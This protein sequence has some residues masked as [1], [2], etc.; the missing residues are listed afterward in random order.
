MNILFVAPYV[1]SRIRV[2]PFHFLKELSKRHD[3]YVVALAEPGGSRFSGVQEI[4]EATRQLRVVPH[5]TARGCVQALLAAPTSRPMCTSYCHSVAMHDAVREAMQSIRFD[6]VHVEHLRA[7]AFAPWSSQIPSLFDSVDCL[8]SLFGQMARA[9]RNPLIKLAMQK[10]AWSLARWEPRALKRFDHAIIT[11]EFE[12]IQMLALDPSLT[13]SVVPNGIDTDYFTPLDC[14]KHPRRF[15][16]NGKMSYA[17]NCQAA[18]WFAENVFPS[19]RATCPDA[20]FVIAGSSPPARL[21]Q[22]S[23]IP[24]ITVT[25]YV[26]DIRPHLDSASVAVAPMQ[27][28]VGVQNKVLEA[29]SMGLPVI[30]SPI[31]ARAFGGQAPGIV[32]ADAPGEFVDAALSFVRQPESAADIGCKGRQEALERF[33]WQSSVGKLESIYQSIIAANARRTQ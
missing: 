13:V 30:A 1:P 17:P 26:H 10:E 25:G 16:F 12:R 28:A 20:E 4:V 8:T 29:M 31:A 9:K 14:Q 24:G 11:S 6:V 27:V 32:V 21:T 23:A 15:I 18:L 3:V 5:S 33:S 22:L 7:A 2:R 19:V